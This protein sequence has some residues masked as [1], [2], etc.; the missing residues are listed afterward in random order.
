MSRNTDTERSQSSRGVGQL[1]S[2]HKHSL[3]S[4]LSASQRCPPR[5]TEA[6][7]STTLASL[8]PGLGLLG[9]G[10]TP[11]AAT[12]GVWEP[13]HRAWVLP[14]KGKGSDNRTESLVASERRDP[15]RTPSGR[16]PVSFNKRQPT[17]HLTDSQTTGSLS[18]RP[19]ELWSREVGACFAGRGQGRTGNAQQHHVRRGYSEILPL[20]GRRCFHM[21]SFT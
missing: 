16:R 9:K 10:Q 7:L 15:A 19:L 11:P 17:A 21:R 13:Q 20:R 6:F 14:S 8:T 3:L 1:R 2:P 18:V 4:V 12:R 5:Q